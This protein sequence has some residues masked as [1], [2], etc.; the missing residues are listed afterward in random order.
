LYI[1]HVHYKR[2][3][4]S[5]GRVKNKD[6]KRHDYQED[7]QIGERKSKGGTER[8]KQG[9]YKT[10]TG[11]GQGQRTGTRKRTRKES[12]KRIRTGARKGTKARTKHRQKE[13][14]GD[15]TGARTWE[16]TEARTWTRRGT[17]TET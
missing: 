16:R 4:T 13:R 14:G 17:W 11:R 7:M 5:T 15:K 3:R 8:R 10:Q 12:R 9:Q 6:R 1:V 2:I